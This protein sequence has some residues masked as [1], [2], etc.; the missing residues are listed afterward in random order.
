M[1]WVVVFVLLTAVVLVVLAR[2][3]SAGRPFNRQV[4]ALARSGE[5]L[6][7]RFPGHRFRA[8]V[9]AP[10]SG[11]REVV[12]TIQPGAADSAA[13]AALPESAADYLLS[14]LDLAGFDSLRVALFDSVVLVRP[15]GRD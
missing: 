15:I 6:G 13:L 7:R 2:A 9:S 5:S 1:I 11:R 3:W 14:R 8:Q 10:D 4:V 12:L